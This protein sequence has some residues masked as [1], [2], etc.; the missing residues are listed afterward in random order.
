MGSGLTV[1]DN[2]IHLDASL[3]ALFAGWPKFLLR[4]LYR[5]SGSNQWY[6]EK[7]Y[8][9]KLS[10]QK[11]IH[12][13]LGYGIPFEDNSVDFIYSSHF[14][15]H[16]YKS[17]TQKILVEAYRVLKKGGRIRITV[18]NL[19][20]AIS[21]YQSGHKEDFLEF[22]FPN[23]QNESKLGTHRY[24]YDFG[25]LKLLL[26]NSGFVEIERF[27]YQTGHTPDIKIL[28]NRP[29]QTLFVEAVKRLD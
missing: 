6:S 16:L 22:F 28:D 13:S 9:D 18:P 19:E 15:E 7:E 20:Y 23:S 8:V 14:I 26:E 12:H 1:A 25:L 29:E 11:F 5:F 4:L 24:M 2:W 27:S 17:E 3:N 10:N 21:L